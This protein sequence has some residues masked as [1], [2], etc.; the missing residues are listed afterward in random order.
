MAGLRG[1]G[2][3]VAGGVGGALALAALGGCVASRQEPG[4]ATAAVA[5]ALAEAGS[6]AQTT[7]IA[8]ELL[9]RGRLT[10]P[11]ADTTL[12]DQLRV[13]DDADAA[14]TTLVPPDA[15]SSAHRADGLAAVGDVTDVVVAAREW[16]AVR[17]GGDLGAGPAGAGELLDDLDQA[18][19]AVDEALAAAGGP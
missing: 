4:Q 15:A 16:V 2:R 14:L 17:S 13:L 9:S 11:V 12:L 6:A 18:A 8:V 1:L 7:R 3:V 10:G 5:D 19:G